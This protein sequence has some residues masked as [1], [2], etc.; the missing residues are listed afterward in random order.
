MTKTK[1]DMDRRISAVDRAY[2]KAVA[3]YDAMRLMDVGGLF[4]GFFVAYFMDPTNRRSRMFEIAHF[5][6]RVSRKARIEFDV[7]ERQLLSQY[8]RANLRLN[9][10]CLKWLEDVLHENKQSR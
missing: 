4:S 1:Q 3:R 5:S 6:V 8:E 2:R 10:I 7:C 9:E